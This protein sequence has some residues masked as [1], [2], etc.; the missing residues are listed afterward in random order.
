MFWVL[1]SNS[2]EILKGE[3]P[4]GLF[5]LGKAF[6][7]KQVSPTEKEA[8]KQMACRKLIQPLFGSWRILYG[9]MRNKTG[10]KTQG[11]SAAAT[12]MSIVLRF[13][14]GS[15]PEEIRMFLDLLF[16]A[17]K[18]FSHG[19]YRQYIPQM[20][21]FL[22]CLEVGG[23][24]WCHLSLTVS[25]EGW[26]GENPRDWVFPEVLLTKHDRCLLNIWVQKNE[27]TCHSFASKP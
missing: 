1:C 24:T 19:R 6:K 7:P 10:N 26:K 11:K 14:A 18:Q 27:V 17:V 9:R 16:E 2:E 13:L 4:P 21:C 23:Y 25:L 3:F 5:T 15:L 22:S 12:R 8:R 20:C